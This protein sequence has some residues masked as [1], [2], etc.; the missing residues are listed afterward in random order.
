M[1]KMIVL[2]LLAASAAIWFA[3]RPGASLQAQPAAT[4]PVPTDWDAGATRI[5]IRYGVK[6]TD[7]VNWKGRIEPA[8][9]GA[10]VLGVEGLHFIQQDRAGRDGSFSFTTRVWTPTNSQVDLS[11][12][13]PG[14]RTV[15]PN[16]VYAVVAGPPDARF[17]VS[18]AGDFTFALN[19][20]AAGRQLNFNDGDIEVEAAP[21]AT[22]L[23]GRAGDKRGEADFRRLRATTA[24]T[25]RSSGRS[26]S[27]SATA[28]SFAKCRRANGARPK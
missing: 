4:A 15:F 26:F 11:P 9:T 7:A 22:L 27:A 14:P 17:K 5:V 23:S 19:D 3:V 25:S 20:L 13:I 1:R 8:S 6:G 16:G 18:G 28:S 2:G 21:N 12:V 10:R 24:D